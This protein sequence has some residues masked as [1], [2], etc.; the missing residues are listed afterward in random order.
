MQIEMTPKRVLSINDKQRRHSVT[1][2]YS[3]GR[4]DTAL[5]SLGAVVGAALTQRRIDYIS[6]PPNGPRVMVNTKSPYLLLRNV[7]KVKWS[8]NWTVILLRGTNRLHGMQ[9]A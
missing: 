2:N 3:L 5:P 1:I 8:D 7:T 9:N 6:V 4:A